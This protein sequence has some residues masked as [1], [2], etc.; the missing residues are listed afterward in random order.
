MQKDGV[1]RELIDGGSVTLDGHVWGIGLRDAN[2]QVVRATNAK[3]L[4]LDRGGVSYPQNALIE[5][6]AA[7]VEMFLRP[8]GLAG[9]NDGAWASVVGMHTGT[10]SATAKK[11][12]TVVWQLR[13]GDGQHRLRVFFQMRSINKDYSVYFP[14]NVNYLDGK[15]HHVAFSFAPIADGSGTLVKLYWDYEKVV[16]QTIDDDVELPTADGYL[17]LGMSVVEG[18]L[19]NGSI[20]ELRIHDG[21]VEPSAF[22]RHGR[23]GFIVIAR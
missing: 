13:Y 21:A 15:W 8:I 1:I 5:T 2:N 17:E 11:S 4:R 10:L 12:G 9:D 23:S 3:S 22:L 6:K 7:T 14:S 16:E 18:R 20:D 19:F